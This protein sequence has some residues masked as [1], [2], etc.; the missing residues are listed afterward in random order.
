[1][2]LKK[3]AFIVGHKLTAQGAVNYLNE[4]EWEF[5]S[6][7]A[8]YVKS[9]FS[10]DQFRVFI[11]T[12]H[13]VKKVKEFNPSMIIELHFNAFELKAYGCEALALENS[14]E[15][16]YE[17][18]NFIN[19]FNKR[20]K[21]KKREVL[22]LQ[23]KFDRG[24]ANFNGLRAYPMFLFEPCFAN[25]KTKDSIK[26]I[27]NWQDYGDFLIDYCNFYFGNKDK[28]TV[29]ILDRMIAIMQSWLPKGV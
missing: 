14:P 2:Y 19:E 4:T 18:N 9:N 3:I 12:T 13:Y 25:F 22:E 11:K 7:I 26:I 1:M 15:S 28:V 27:E 24:F 16:I 6:S 10:T 17:A 29:N 20:F 21:I 8:N 23:G 5:N